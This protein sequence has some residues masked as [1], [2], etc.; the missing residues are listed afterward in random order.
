MNGIRMDK[1]SMLFILIVVATTLWGGIF[2]FGPHF[3]PLKQPST[4]TVI[5][6]EEDILKDSINR[7]IKLLSANSGNKN[8]TTFVNLAAS[9]KNPVL[10]YQYYIRAYGE[11]NKE[12]KNT[13]DLKIKLSMIRLASYLSTLPQ[14]KEGDVVIPK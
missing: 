4:Q 9:E 8:I 11:M 14:Y 6:S 3:K 1:K 13:K 2:Y 7:N 5:K 12:Y 10:S